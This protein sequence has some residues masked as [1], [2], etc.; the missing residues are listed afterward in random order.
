[1][2]H[3]GCFSHHDHEHYYAMLMLAEQPIETGPPC[4]K[5]QEKTNHQRPS[6]SYE[7]VAGRIRDLRGL[8]GYFALGD[9]S[10]F[11]PTMGNWTFRN[12]MHSNAE[13]TEQKLASWSQDCNAEIYI[14]RNS[15][16]FRS[17]VNSNRDL[18][19]GQIMIRIRISKK[20]VMNNIVLKFICKYTT[21]YYKR[22]SIY[23]FIPLPHSGVVKP[24]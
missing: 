11:R 8:S 13:L 24:S 3:L 4:R 10:N 12:R 2:V 7:R 1:M 9:I 21:K 22:R 20:V 5:A 14:M 16:T 18:P 19:M 23:C 17:S 6:H 15:T